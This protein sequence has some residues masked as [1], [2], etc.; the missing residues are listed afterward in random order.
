MEKLPK[1]T[2]SDQEKRRDEALKNALWMPPKP[3]TPKPA[4]KA[5]PRKADKSKK[6]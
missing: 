4:L 1:D 6:S 2:K 5:K 3:F